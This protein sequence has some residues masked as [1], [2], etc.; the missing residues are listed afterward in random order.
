MATFTNQAS[1]SYTG[2]TVTSNVTVGEILETVT[3]TKTAVT[4][5]YTPGG[6]VSYVINVINSGAAPTAALTLTDDLGA[7]EVGAE[8][9]YPL[10]YREGSL[11]YFLEGELQTAPATDVSAGLSFTPGSIPAD[12]VATFIYEA[13]VTGYADPTGSVTNTVTLTGTPSPV[14]ASATVTAAAVPALGITKTLTP[15]TVEEG[16]GVTYGF[17]VENLSGT[18]A[19]EDQQITLTDTF[20]PALTNI[21]VTLDGQTMTEG[22]DYTYDVTTGAFATVPGRITVPAAAFTPSPAGTWSVTPGTAEITVSGTL[23]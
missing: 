14:T 15:L 11:L 19:G 17:S 21:T 20:D 22:T 1:L 9:V 6:T 23:N 3:V 2:G 5:T 10:A 16:G 18:A 8:T 12:S 13:E 7:Y 4:E